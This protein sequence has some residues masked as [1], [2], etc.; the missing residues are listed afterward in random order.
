MRRILSGYGKPLEKA[1]GILN[2]RSGK[3][4]RRRRDTG[5]N[6]TLFPRSNNISVE[7]EDIQT[8]DACD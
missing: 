2:W 3:L 8:I 6:P 5:L 1:G 4:A 7:D